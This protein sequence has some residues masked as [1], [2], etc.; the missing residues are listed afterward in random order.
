MRTRCFWVLLLIGFAVCCCTGGI[1]AHCALIAA[2]AGLDLRAMS[3]AILLPS[4]LAALGANLAA[5]RA[6]DAGVLGVHALF[7]GSELLLA[8]AAA[9]GAAMGA[10]ATP[11]GRTAAAAAFGALYGSGTGAYYF[12]YKVAFAQFFGRKSIGEIMGI[13][14]AA[15]FAGIGL[16]PVLFGV[17]RDAQG[18]Y[19]PA[20][21]ASVATCAL[22]AAAAWL[23]VVPPG[24]RPRAAGEGA[25]GGGEEEEEGAGRAPLLGAGE[26]EQRPASARE[27]RPGA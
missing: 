15:M 2:D 10:A 24:A 20:L 19:G 12:L 25:G 27:Q 9:A 26:Q 1:T 13:A 8:A 23:L 11:A 7:A 18:S 14:N 21:R 16:G 3:R 6:L 5:G 4:A 22:A 17:A